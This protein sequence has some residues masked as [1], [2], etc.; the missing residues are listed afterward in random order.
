MQKI[1]SSILLLLTLAACGPRDRIQTGAVILSLDLDP[2]GN[3]VAAAY[4]LQDRYYVWV[5]GRV[6][7]PFDLVFYPRFSDYAPYPLLLTLQKE[8]RWTIR[9]GEATYGP[10]SYGG[11]PP[12][13]EISS[14][15]DISIPYQE[16]GQDYFQLNEYVLGPYEKAGGWVFGPAAGHFAFWFIQDTNFMYSV[17]GSDFVGGPEYHAPFFLGDDGLGLIRSVRRKLFLS[18][19][20]REFGPFDFVLPPV[21]ARGGTEYAILGDIGGQTYIITSRDRLGPFSEVQGPPRFSPDGSRMYFILTAGADNDRSYS[22]VLDGRTW[23]PYSSLSQPRWSAD[24]RH[25]AWIARSSN[26]SAAWLDG[27]AVLSLSGPAAVAFSEQSLV[28][29]HVSNYQVLRQTLP[30]AGSNP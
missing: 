22:L 15:N 14:M 16:G 30:L 12:R 1:L 5:D 28:V 3:R 21:F 9:F 2:A 26:Q 13:P 7:G 29:A 20:N 25:L 18:I 24:S 23:G 11:P 19:N 10:F 17:D 4:R 27:E 8:K 6:E